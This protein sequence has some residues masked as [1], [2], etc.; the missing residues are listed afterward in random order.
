MEKEIIGTA[1]EASEK[2]YFKMECIYVPVSLSFFAA[3]V[4]SP[5]KE[6]PIKSHGQFYFPV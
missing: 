4:L 5:V 2:K 3:S 1:A 6:M